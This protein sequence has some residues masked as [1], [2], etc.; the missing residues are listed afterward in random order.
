MTVAVLFETLWHSRS[1]GWSIASRQYA[2]CMHEAGL[3]VGIHSWIG[4][5]EDPEPEVL[6]EVRHLVRPDVR[7]G[8]DLYVFSCTLYGWWALQYSVTALRKAR[9]PRAFYT[10]FERQGIEP[11]AVE[12][13]NDLEG[14][15]VP[16]SFNRDVLAAAG[17]KN[18]TYVPYPHFDDDPHLALPPPSRDPRRFY[19]IGRWE[20][21]KASHNLVRAFLAAFKPGEATLTL[22]LGPVPWPEE[23]GYPPPEE[24][25]R[26]EV[27]RSGRWTLAAA[28]DDVRVVRGRLP[29]DE[30]VRLHAE[31]DVYVSASRGEGIDLPG[32]CAKLAGRRIVTTDSGGP[33]DFLTE[34]DVLVPQTGEVPA[35]PYY[36][37][38][39][40]AALADYDLA[41]LV[42]AM[43]VARADT[44]PPERID[45]RF[46]AE[47]VG[48][49][50]RAWAED[51]VERCPPEPREPPKFTKFAG[52][53]REQ[54]GD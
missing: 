37:W 12:P 23:R 3:R 1:D 13:L 40:D 17:V 34:T 30:L 41:A 7:A 39:E 20:P 25:I 8:R 14:V 27:G 42:A 29:P 46:R 35:D 16:C 51:I 53:L 11:A 36:R 31:H 54:G 6:E 18:V 4:A 9:R 15:W 38:G 19:W 44:R 26:D 32:Y 47:N 49:L 21:R 33:R 45:A 10:M 50:L 22:K 24:I 28:L 2:R 5:L 52:W 43:Q 48:P